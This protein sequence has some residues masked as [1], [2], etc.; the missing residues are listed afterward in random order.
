MPSYSLLDVAG[1]SY[2]YIG[3]GRYYGTN[4]SGIA[5]ISFQGI[6]AGTMLVSNTIIKIEGS[7]TEKAI[8][9]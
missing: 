9:E 8:T 4:V 2:S 6:A 3:E 7:L 5:T 1:V